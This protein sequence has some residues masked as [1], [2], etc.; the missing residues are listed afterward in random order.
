MNLVTD[1]PSVDLWDTFIALIL[2]GLLASIVAWQYVKFGR[3]FTNRSSL[4]YTLPL[5]TITIVLVIVVVKSS[6]ALSLGLVGALSIVRF[7]TPVKEV[8]ELAY[9]FIAIA[10]GIGLGASQW[11]PTIL[12]TGLILALST[13]RTLISRRP[14]KRN[15]YLDISIPET[16]SG[17]APYYRQLLESLGERV[18]SVDLRRLDVSDDSAQV[19]CYIKARD[20]ETVMAAI[21]ELK[22]SL[23]A[24]TTITFIDQDSG[25]GI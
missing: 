17:G 18:D 6:I 2:G 23:P 24:S 4:A 10:I 13:G 9:L 5:I 7:R 11:W 12:A 20:D 25:S 14:T 8:E 1:L 16:N 15:L 19:T 21:E 22:T 3:T